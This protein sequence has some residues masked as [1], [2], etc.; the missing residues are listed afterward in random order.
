MNFKKAISFARSAGIILKGVVETLVKLER[1]KSNGYNGGS[2]CRRKRKNRRNR[3]KK[4]M[5]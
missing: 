4:D 2:Y 5:I 1:S 3:C